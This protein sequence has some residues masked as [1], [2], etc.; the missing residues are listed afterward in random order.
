MVEGMSITALVGSFIAVAIFLSIGTMILGGA[1]LDCTTLDG[2]DATTPSASTSWAGA[3]LDQ[4]EQT[5]SAYAL[6]LVVLIVIAAVVI[7]TVVRM[8]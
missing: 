6:L 4:Q 3:C 8:L 2:Y 7:L 1:T 5:Q